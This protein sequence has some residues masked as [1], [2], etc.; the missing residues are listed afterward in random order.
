MVLGRGLLFHSAND[1]VRR[2]QWIPACAG[3]TRLNINFLSRL[4]R[5]RFRVPIPACAGMTI[6]VGDTRS[7]AIVFHP[8]SKL[9]RTQWIPTFVGMTRLNINFLSRLR[10]ARFRAPIPACAGMTIFVGD[11]RSG[12]IVS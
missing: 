6:F 4:C 5:A 7:G 1:K 9:R 2:T 10:C 11:A 3:M 8:V 12:S